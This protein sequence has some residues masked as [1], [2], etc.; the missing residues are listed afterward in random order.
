MSAMSRATCA[1]G[2]R[3]WRGSRRIASTLSWH[4]GPGHDQPDWV[5]DPDPAKASEIEIRFTAEEPGI[6]LVELTHSKLER[7]GEGYEKLRAALEGP[8]A[9]GHILELY[10]KAASADR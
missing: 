3:C 2:A 6:T 7:H 10:A 5:A 4:V 8:G 9:W 1:I